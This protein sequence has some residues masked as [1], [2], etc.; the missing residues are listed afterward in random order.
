MATRVEW[1]NGLIES[2]LAFDAKDGVAR[3]SLVQEGR[4]SVDEDDA[5]CAIALFNSLGVD[6]WLDESC[7]AIDVVG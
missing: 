4:S 2:R 3:I 5:L 1:V 7:L 6:V